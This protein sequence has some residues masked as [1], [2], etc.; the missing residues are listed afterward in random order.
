MILYVA[1]NYLVTLD[2]RQEPPTRG[3]VKGVDGGGIGAFVVHPTEPLVVVGEKG[4]DPNL[5]IF[6]YPSWEVVKVLRKG[7]EQGYSTLCFSP[8]GEM[9]AS[10]AA[11][12]DFI[13]SVWD[14]RQ[15]RVTLHTKAFGQDVFNVAFSLDDPGRLVTSGTGHIRFWKMARTFTGLKLQVSELTVVVVGN[16][17][18]RKRG[19]GCGSDEG[20]GGSLYLFQSCDFAS[21]WVCFLSPP[22]LSFF[23]S[24][25]PSFL[26]YT[27]V[28]H[29][30]T[31]PLL[32]KGDIGKFGKIELSDVDAF[33]EMPDG[34]VL[35]ST[36]TGS[37]LVWEGNFIK[38]RIMRHAGAMCHDAVS[39]ESGG[40]RRISRWGNLRGKLFHPPID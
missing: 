21:I 28:S 17:V 1:G 31:T 4:N 26:S 2:L 29:C 6:S 13:L 11:G 7:A 27:P 19:C 23:L 25:F 18:V 40:C 37:L 38:Y 24:L 30:T 9:L 39:E 15:E 12:P 5:Y 22:P 35:S 14:W 16:G 20:G 33:V 10:V 34:K 3:Y 8:N 32:Q 36:E